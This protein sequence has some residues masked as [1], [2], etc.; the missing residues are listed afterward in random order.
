M[1]TQKSAAQPPLIM[2]NNKLQMSICHKSLVRGFALTSLTLL[3]TLTAQGEGFRNPPPGTFNLGRAGGRIAQVDD[4]SAVQQN[5][6]NLVT[7]TNVQLQFTPTVVFIEAEYTS[8]L[9]VPAQTTD[10]VK[11]L[12]NFFATTP[13]FEGRAAAGLGIT[14]P[15]GLGSEWEQSGSFAD[16]F[17]LRYQAPWFAEMK[18]INFNPTFA[19]RLNDQLSLG[20]GLNAMWS[21][22]TFKQFYP[23]LIFPGSLG[24]E[25]DGN[26]EAQG[27]GVGYGVN[28]GLTWEPAEGHRFA[29]TYRSAMSVDYDGRFTIDNVTP[30]AAFLGVTSSSDFATKIKF[31]TIIAA[32]YGVQATDKLRLEANVEWLEFSNFD[33]LDL[34]AGNNNLLLP[35][36]SLPQNWR[37]TYTVGIGGD[38]QLSPAWIVRFGY[39]YYQSPVPDETLSPTIPDA[40]QNVFTIG[41]GYQKG[42]HA[43]EFGYG[44]DFYEDRTVTTNPNPA[45]NGRY[46]F[47]VHLFSLAYRLNF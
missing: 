35:S 41:L 1:V 40:N 13:L 42:R 12:P 37:N 6:A 31:P 46:E 4:A 3:V 45:L 7:L 20:A 15:Y 47:N 18:T 32:G 14:T 10:P 11:I 44:L 43:F 23:W 34:N 9:G 2:K 33:S 19:Y 27:D 24:G 29:L 39:Q 8:P 5:P 28:L 25:P 30:T 17:G 21:E 16:P 26:I 22:L 36:T 38:Y